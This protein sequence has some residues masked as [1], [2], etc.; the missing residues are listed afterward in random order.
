MLGDLPSVL[1]PGS[2]LETNCSVRLQYFLSPECWQYSPSAWDQMNALAIAA[3]PIPQPSPPGGPQTLTQE[4]VPGAFT[5]DQAIAAGVAQTT[6][7]LR[8][9][10]G[11]AAQSIAAAPNLQTGP[12]VW[13]WAAL[14]LGG[15]LG[16]DLLKKAV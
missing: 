10:F 11:G 16:F 14:I 7:N 12:S 3:G 9:Y 6:A 15:L 8:D 4:T 5:P 1:N 13:F 2:L